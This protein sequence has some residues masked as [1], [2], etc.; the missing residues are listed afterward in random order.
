VSSPSDPLSSYLS[1]DTTTVLSGTDNSSG[2]AGTI[3]FETLNEYSISSVS[4]NTWSLCIFKQYHT[5][6]AVRNA[7]DTLIIT[8]SAID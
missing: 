7:N 6:I 8:M 3:E 5:T 1:S 2:I 4:G